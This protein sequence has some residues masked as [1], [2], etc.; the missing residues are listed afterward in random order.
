MLRYANKIVVVAD[1]QIIAEHKR[2]F[3]KNI[4]Y[5]EPWHYVPLLSRKPGALRNGAPFIEWQL[6]AAMNKIKAHYMDTKGGDRD[7]VDL[8]M[9]ACEHGI[10]TVEIACDLAVEQNTLRLPAI[11]NL[12]NQLVEPVIDPLPQS[13]C[14]PQLQVMPEAD[15]KRYEQLYAGT[16][17]MA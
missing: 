11:T 2:R 7:F 13:H 14:Y 9:M 16:Q 15:C 17:V 3:T 1:Q 8:L 5:F 4:S 10:G 6:P 12:I